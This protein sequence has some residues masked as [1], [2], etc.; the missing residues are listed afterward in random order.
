MTRTAG[1]LAAVLLGMAGFVYLMQDRF[2]YFPDRDM[3]DAPQVTRLGLTFWPAEGS[4]FL[5]YTQL[6]V[7]ENPG[8]TLVVF[9]GNAGAAWHREYFASWLTPLGYRVILAEYPGYGG[10]TGKMGE[11][12]FVEDAT[13]TV[14]LAYEQFGGPLFLVGE[15]L[16]CGVAAG[17]AANPPVPVAGVLMITPWDNL[18]DLA[19]TLYPFLPVRWF[20]RD[21]YDN[22]QNLNRFDGP[23][24]VAVAEQ[25]EIIP[26]SHG[27]RLYEALTGEKQ[28]YL[29]S[30]AYH[31]TWQSLVG[32]AWW[33]E[34]MAFLHGEASSER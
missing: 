28:L 5:G 1:V 27:I 19:K 2:L 14:A 18:P 22:R 9:H 7:P 8:G 32:A 21:V 15:S 24:A 17:V 30:G 31:N 11:K 23:S 4:S 29:I 10:R 20:L 12:P 6:Q 33:G 34:V 16:G 3:P 13:K 26:K 25:D